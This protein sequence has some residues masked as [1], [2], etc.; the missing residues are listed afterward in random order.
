MK[1]TWMFASRVGLTLMAIAVSTAGQA[2]AG[3]LPHYTITDLGTL[4]GAYSYAY[5][6]NEAG[7]VSGGAATDSET[8]GLDQKGFLWKAGAITNVGT[9]GGYACPDCSS[10]AGGPNSSGQSAVV[11]ET[12]KPAFMNED[13]CGFGTH[14]QCLGAVWKHGALKALPNLRGGHNG[15]AYWIN[16]HGQLAGLTETGVLD[17][18]CAS[19]VPF[20][21]LRFEAVVWGP[22]GKVRE[23]RPLPGDT[24]GFAF[25]INDEGQVV[26]ASGVCSNT[27]LP[28][29]NVDAPHAVLWGSDGK[30]IDLGTLAGQ[31]HNVAGSI[32]NLGD[33]NGTSLVD[34]GTVHTF[35][36]KKKTGMQDI[37]TLPGAIVTVAPCCHTLNN[38]DEMTGFWI[39]GDG[40]MSPFYWK[41]NVIT[42]MNTLISADSGWYL[43]DT[44]SI[45]DAG[46]IA[47]TGVNPDGE[48]HAFLATPCPDPQGTTEAAIVSAQTNKRP[49]PAVPESVRWFINQQLRHAKPGAPR[50]DAQ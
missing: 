6:I 45:N 34:D 50:I 40:N 3:K 43:L 10:E 12:P 2:Q 23:L 13:F 31:P 32:N 22:E 46:Q 19:S 49:M 29:V 38:K 33:V 30:P 48:V 8:D 15:Q 47:G 1:S 5:G 37:G 14:R 9:I 26:G 41:D 4:G 16:K 39:D 24:V 18:T 42:D 27:S 36:W 28:P 35:L 44:A 20:Q 21:E 17:S 25:G 11:S 7:E